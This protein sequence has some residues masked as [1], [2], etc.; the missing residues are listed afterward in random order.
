MAI[1]FSAECKPSAT[2]ECP[3]TLH[4][5]EQR[6]GRD[7]HSMHSS[8]QS[9]SLAREGAI[10]RTTGTRSAV[11]CSGGWGGGGYIGAPNPTLN[12]PS[13]GCLRSHAMF[14]TPMMFRPFGVYTRGTPAQLQVGETPAPSLVLDHT[15]SPG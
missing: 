2:A 3:A 4:E 14:E 13:W 8:C 12:P 15:N 6:C 1:I 11:H 5:R 9:F 10:P 7:L